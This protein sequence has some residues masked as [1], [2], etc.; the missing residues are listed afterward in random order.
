M[1]PAG[2]DEGLARGPVVVL[3]G[4][5]WIGRWVC[6][7]FAA[8]GRPVLAVARELRPLPR[9]VRLFRL[10]AAGLDTAGLACLLA[11]ERPA[12]VVNAAGGYWTGSLAHM[13]HSF[14]EVTRRLMGAIDRLPE[15]PRVVHLGT[16][17]EYAPPAY[18]VPL[19][20]DAPTAP[21]TDYGR[22]KLA[23]TR[24]V[25]DAVRAGRADAVVLRLA[26]VCGIGA[27][28]QSLPGR[29]AAELAEAALLGRPA[30]LE[31][32]GLTG[33]RDYVDVRDVARAIVAAATAPDPGRRLFNI[34]VGVPVPVREVVDGLIAASGV[35]SDLTVHPV[36][37]GPA[38]GG[39][40]S[41]VDPGAA[42]QA[43]GWRAEITFAE[44]LAAHWADV[45]TATRAAAEPD[46]SAA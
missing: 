16:V 5:G 2:P 23:S 9:N 22:I 43:L 1:R 34:G 27:P 6:A 17:L 8:T 36:Q 26:N 33:H 42:A 15:R 4:T 45:S 39:L 29:V 21:D 14:I 32:T 35:P 12:I 20:E 41:A 7:A 10:D 28:V 37:P 25:T 18:G 3:G 44:S 31:F 11:A 40:W 46:W 38:A 19:T 30:R 13:E 24:M